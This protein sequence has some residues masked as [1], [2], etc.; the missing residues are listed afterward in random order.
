GDACLMLAAVGD[1]LLRR[2]HRLA[3]L[4]VQLP[5]PSTVAV[6]LAVGDA[7]L[8]LAAVGDHLLRR[9]HRLAGLAVQLPL[10]ST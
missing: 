2:I 10:P 4:A 8:M 6:L 1:H 7:C 3:G 5:L 9:I